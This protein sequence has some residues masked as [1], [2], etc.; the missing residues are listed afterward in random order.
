MMITRYV[1]RHS[2]FRLL[3]SLFLPLSLHFSECYFFFASLVILFIL[4]SVWIF[5]MVCGASRITAQFYW[6][7]HHYIR[8]CNSV[9]FSFYIFYIIFHP[10]H[11]DE[12][13][14]S[15]YQP[16]TD[17]GCGAEPNRADSPWIISNISKFR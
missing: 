2:Y 4:F 1:F 12:S 16:I 3:T 11:S 8:I 17:F 13:R 14:A 7:D 10:F 9:F 6:V 15:L 5:R